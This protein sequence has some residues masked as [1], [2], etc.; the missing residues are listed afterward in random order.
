M[1]SPTL[2]IRI[3]KDLKRAL[4]KAAKA[5]D[6]SVTSYVVHAIKEQ[7]QRVKP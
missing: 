7:L 4:A 3:P 2:T 5:D 1:D 6:R